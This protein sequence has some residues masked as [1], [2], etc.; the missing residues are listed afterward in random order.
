MHVAIAGQPPQTKPP[1]P[2]PK[3]APTPPVSTTPGTTPTSTEEAALHIVFDS[4]LAA[5]AARVAATD[6]LA[7]GLTKEARESMELF[8]DNVGD[9]VF[10]D[11]EDDL[12][13][14]EEVN[15]H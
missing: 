2:P 6:Q 10:D 8:M 13:P 15:R 14:I 5:A 9:I 1:P 11:F 3:R 4:L 7:D 12:Y